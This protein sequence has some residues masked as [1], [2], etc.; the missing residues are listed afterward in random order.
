MYLLILYMKLRQGYD[1]EEFTS[2]Y[3]SI[4]SIPIVIAMSERP[5][6]TS[7]YVSINSCFHFLAV[8]VCYNLH[9]T[10]YLLI[11]FIVCLSFSPL[12]HLH[13]TM[14]LLI[15]SIKSL[16]H[17]SLIFTSH[18]VSINSQMQYPFNKVLLKFTSHYVSINSYCCQF[19]LH[20]FL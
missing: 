11:P 9:P 7:H 20:T 5:I 2:H 3:V 15:P 17:G 8:Y 12:V 18:Y 19:H 10:M 14:Y 16:R 13:P 1:R 4:N 6:F